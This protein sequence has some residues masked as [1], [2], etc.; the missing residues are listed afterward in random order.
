VAT[1]DRVRDHAVH[2]QLSGDCLVDPIFTG[3]G[4]VA[5]FNSVGGGGYAG[6]GK[7]PVEN[8]GAL[9]DGSN[10]AHW[11]ETVFGAEL[12]TPALDAGVSNPLS[13]VT[14]QSLG[15]L[16]YAVTNGGA[17]GYALPAPG[18]AGAAAREGGAGVVLLNDVLPTP[19][20]RI[21][22]DGRVEVVRP[23]PGPARR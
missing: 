23:G 18:P 13:I 14:V 7:V 3:A 6:G 8:T 15:D 5:A 11:R 22:P 10:C 17:D 4:A 19:L 1:G 20:L 12:M 2:A 21:R 9:D 16:G